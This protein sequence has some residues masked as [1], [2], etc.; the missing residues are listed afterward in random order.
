MPATMDQ[1]V[2]DLEA[3]VEALEGGKKPAKPKAKGKK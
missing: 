1:K 2:A 3:R